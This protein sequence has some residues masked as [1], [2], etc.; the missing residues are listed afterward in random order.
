MRIIT[1]KRIVEFS[2]IHADAEQAL[3]EWY[4]TTLHCDWRN[5]AEMKATFGSVDAAGNDRFVFNIRGNRYR[6][7]AIVIFAVRKVFIRFIGTHEEYNKIDC[8]TI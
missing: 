2:A 4:H 5:F 8:S 3:S 6:L 7:V 1:R